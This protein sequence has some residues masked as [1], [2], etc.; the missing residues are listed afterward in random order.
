VLELHY[1]VPTA[2]GHLS[3]KVLRCST[4]EDFREAIAK[5]KKYGYT[6]LQN[7]MCRDCKKNGLECEGTVSYVWTGCVLREK[8]G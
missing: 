6:V 3:E 5:C 2:G 1:L 4:Y 7:P 8:A